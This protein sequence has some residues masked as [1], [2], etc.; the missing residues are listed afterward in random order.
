MLDHREALYELL[1]KTDMRAEW[2]TKMENAEVFNEEKCFS[3]IWFVMCHMIMSLMC[4]SMSSLSSFILI[5]YLWGWKRR[6]KHRE[7]K[8]LRQKWD[9]TLESGKHYL[10]IRYVFEETKTCIFPYAFPPN[11]TDKINYSFGNVYF[12]SKTRV[13][14]A[15]MLEKCSCSNPHLQCPHWNFC[16]EFQQ[17]CPRAWIK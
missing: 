12:T 17:K 14:Q 5:L 2:A 3:S 7:M 1:Y 11:N 4:I 13:T 6:Y 9:F 16:F 8:Y 15:L 10:C